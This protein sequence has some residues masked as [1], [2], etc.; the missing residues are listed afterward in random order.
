[1]SKPSVDV[2]VKIVQRET[3]KALLVALE[4][5]QEIWMPKSQIMEGSDVS[6]EGDSGI[7]KI[8][9]WIAG[10]KGLSGGND[11]EPTG[12]PQPSL[13]ESYDDIPF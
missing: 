3:D 5:G 4:N 6:S 8:S 9:E 10:E 11:P 1:M 12:V 2:V 7:M 13:I